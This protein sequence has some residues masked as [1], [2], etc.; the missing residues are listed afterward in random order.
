M[1]MDAFSNNTSIRDDGDG[2]ISG[3]NY[4]LG[5]WIVGSVSESITSI[6]RNNYL[7]SNIIEW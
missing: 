4:M 7:R 6:S 2:V 5:V 3:P 1:S